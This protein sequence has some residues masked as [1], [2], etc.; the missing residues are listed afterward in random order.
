M[1][2]ALSMFAAVALSFAGFSATAWSFSHGA[3]DQAIAFAWPT[4][5]FLIALCVAA[6]W[7]L[8]RAA[9]PEN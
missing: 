8:G 2:R 7:R 5:A 6:P 4:L 1:I 9:R 3:L